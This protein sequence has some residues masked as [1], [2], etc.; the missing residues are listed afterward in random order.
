M[1]DLIKSIAEKAGISPEQAKTAADV[2]KDY[3]KENAGSLGM[4]SIKDQMGDLKEDAEEK[5]VELKKDAEEAFE[6]VKNSISGIFG[7]GDE[8]KA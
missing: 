7:G 8:K 1:E 3:F 5:F 6:K 4:E 2:A